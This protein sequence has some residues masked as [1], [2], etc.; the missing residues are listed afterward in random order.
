MNQN[1]TKSDAPLRQVGRNGFTLIELLAVIARTADLYDGYVDTGWT[2]ELINRCIIARHGG[3]P[4]GSAPK[5]ASVNQ[6]FPGS[7]NVSLF[8][9][10]VENCK[11]D[12]LWFYMWSGTY[13]PLP[14]R[15]G[16]P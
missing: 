14:K 10:H 16:L 1:K 11:L 7:V 3:R 9:G 2:P 5:R 4:A 15:P 13:V 6:R 8:D 12:G